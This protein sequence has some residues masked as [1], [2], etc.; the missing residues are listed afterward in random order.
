MEHNLPAVGRLGVLVRIAEEVVASARAAWAPDTTPTKPRKPN[1]AHAVLREPNAGGESEGDLDV[2]VIGAGVAGLS[3][4]RD[5]VDAGKNVTIVEARDR[6]GGRMWTQTGALSAPVELGAQFI[7]GRSASTWELVRQQGLQIHTHGNTFSR[8]RVGGPWK[9]KNRKFPY[10]FQVVGGYNQILAPLAYNLSIDLNTVVRRVEYSP[11]R[12]IVHAEQEGRPVTYHARA[13]VVTLPVAVLNADAVEFSP[14]LPTEK[15]EAFKA[16]PHVA[17]SKLA[18]EF[19]RPVFP[20][21][22]DHVIEAGQDMWLMNGAMG[23]PQY[24]GRIVIAGA[25]EG[26]A[27]RL[28]ALP[29]EQRHREYLEVF[30]GIARDRNLTP[31]KVIEH[32]WA[33]DPFARAAFTDSWNVSGVRKIYQ[34]VDET[35]FWA[36]VITDQIDFSHDSGKQAATQLLSRLEQAPRHTQSPS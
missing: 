30:R 13:S 16:V 1:T 8:T 36:G 6:I 26:E 10:N 15:S 24:S 12:V 27:E 33:D 18:M 2:I 28:L 11:G 29:A 32:V 9:K 22:A 3:A 21:D 5:L 14:T 17:I 35:L 4:A 20:D 23:N 31:I 19:D 7:H 34:P 25:E